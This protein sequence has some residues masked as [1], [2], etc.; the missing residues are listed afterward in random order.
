MMIC[1]NSPRFCNLFDSVPA[2]PR[3]EG[4]ASIVCLIAADNSDH[5][6]VFLV[7]VSDLHLI[8]FLGVEWASILVDIVASAH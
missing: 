4:V 1:P 7:S 8:T 5:P 3:P 6:D 2:V